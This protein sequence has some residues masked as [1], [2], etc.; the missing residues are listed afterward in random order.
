MQEVEEEEEEE[1][2]VEVV[3]EVEVEVVQVQVQVQTD[4]RHRSSK[5]P[6]DEAASVW[7]SV[8]YAGCQISYI[9]KIGHY[10]MKKMNV[11]PAIFVKV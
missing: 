3:V 4:L 2:E 7:L 1:V 11:G 8:G 6:G 9:I 5:L 10:L